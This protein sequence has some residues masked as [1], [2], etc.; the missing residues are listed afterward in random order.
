[1]EKN[2]CFRICEGIEVKQQRGFERSLR[3]KGKDAIEKLK[4]FFKPQKL[5][6]SSEG[7][8]HLRTTQFYD[9]A[10]EKVF[11]RCSDC[12]AILGIGIDPEE[13]ERRMEK[14]PRNLIIYESLRR[15]RQ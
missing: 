5:P 6:A 9:I 8:E 10:S 1:M 4:E 12:G 3:K 2:R 15:R 11:T 13:N 14:D 7:C